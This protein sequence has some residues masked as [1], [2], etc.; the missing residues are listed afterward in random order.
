MGPPRQRREDEP[1]GQ[2]CPG[3]P[4]L[5]AA[6]G[7][8]PRTSGPAHTVTLGSGLQN[9]ERIEFCCSKHPP[10]SRYSV[11]QHRAL[12]QKGPQA[13]ERPTERRFCPGPPFL[14]SFRLP[15]SGTPAPCPG[16]RRGREGGSGGHGRWRLGPPGKPPQ[17][18][19]YPR[20]S[21]QKWGDV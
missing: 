18:C 6:G 15:P 3:P 7:A 20:Q 5:G 1:T 9:W 16:S 8:S 19:V 11:A 4:E 13:R 14:L 21:C 10:P 17:L 12:A 2:G